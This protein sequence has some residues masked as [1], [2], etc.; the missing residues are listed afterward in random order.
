MRDQRHGSVR[1]LPAAGWAAPAASAAAAAS[2]PPRHSPAR[3]GRL[4]RRATRARPAP[5]RAPIGTAGLGGGHVHQRR[6]DHPLQRDRGLQPRRRRLPGRRCRHRLSTPCSPTTR[7]R[8]RQRRH[9]GGRLQRARAGRPTVYNSL[10]GTSPAGAITGCGSLVGLKSEPRHPRHNGGPTQTIAL[11]PGSLAIGGRHEPRGNNVHPAVHR[12]ARLRPDRA[13][14]WDIGAYQS[15]GVPAP[16]P[17]A[18]LVGEQRLG[19]R[20]INGMAR[21]ATTF[22]VTYYGAAGIQASTVPGAVVTVT[23]PSNVN[24]GTPIT[25]TVVYLVQRMADP[26]GDSQTITVA[27]RSRRRAARGLRPT[28]GRTRSA[29]AACR[30][31]T[32]WQ[33]DPDRARWAASSSRPPTSP[34]PSTAW[35]RTQK[36]QHLERDDQAD[37]QRRRGLQRAD[38]RP[39]QSAGGRGPDERQ[40]DLRRD[41][42]SA[43]QRLEPG[44]GRRP[45]APRCS[46][47]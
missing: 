47:T 41:A 26:F 33:D 12:P 37:Q 39:V 15:T 19:Q 43:G 25:A 20:P 18:T 22:T 21:P 7:L 13:R 3:T 17:T 34:S 27:T 35:S 5:P 30:S 45:S 31:P 44:G 40:R 32:R 23:P 46:S 24:G 28:T 1:S 36:T 9:G 10:F 2:R 14:S 11:L 29:W 4:D 6:L 42:V 38:L 8:D 16:A